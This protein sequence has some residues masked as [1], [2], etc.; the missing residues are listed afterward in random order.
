MDL[1]LH[2]CLTPF[3]VLVTCR[4]TPLQATG[5]SQAQPD[6]QHVR[7]VDERVKQSHRYD[8]RTGQGRTKPVLLTK[9]IVYTVVG[10]PPPETPSSE[11]QRLLSEVEWATH[12]FLTLIHFLWHVTRD[13][14]A[15]KKR[16]VQLDFDIKIVLHTS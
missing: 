6:I 15:G 3:L 13:C 14:S 10:V 11:P 1:P 16:Y 9:V 5:G 2:T 7:Q 8:V 4:V 12:L